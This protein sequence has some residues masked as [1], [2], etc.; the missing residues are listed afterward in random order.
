MTERLEQWAQQSPERIFLA[1]RTAG[2]AWRSL[3][4]A[5]AFDQVRRLAS[6]LV[7]DVCGRWS[8]PLEFVDSA[9]ILAGKR[10]V[11]THA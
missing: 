11:T 8:I 3:T 10:G 7:A 4:Y 6:A 2:G 9:G 5:A 1:S